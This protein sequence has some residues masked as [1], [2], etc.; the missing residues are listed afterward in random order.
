MKGEL[1]SKEE[2]DMRTEEVTI[3]KFIE[4]CP[5]CGLE[6]RNYSPEAVKYNL[7]IHLEKC[8]KK[9]SGYKQK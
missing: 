4:K 5:L 9:F 8:S 6:M 7:R 3:K 1:N 2:K